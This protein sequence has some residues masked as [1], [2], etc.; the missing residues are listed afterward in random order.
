[1]S[2]HNV[3][4]ATAKPAT[5]SDPVASNNRDVLNPYTSLYAR[6]A[7]GQFVMASEGQIL[8]EASRVIDH[9]YQTGTEFIQ[10]NVAEE[11]F[12]AKLAG[13]EREVFA[14]AFLNNRNELITYREL[15]FGSISGVEIHPREVVRAAMSHN[16]AAVILA[17]NHP[18][19]YAQ[20][21]KEDI[22][23]TRRLC[24]A[25]KLLDVKVLDHIIVAG[26]D[27]VSM[28]AQGLM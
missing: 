27:C 11:F 7:D 19:F 28:A 9:R 2:L 1:M 5:A 22:R 12:R 8:S 24:D 15:F 10:N 3:Q 18:S 23:I 20:V 25:M 6:N 16:A 13:C 21:S 4:G 14:V 17:H 26:N